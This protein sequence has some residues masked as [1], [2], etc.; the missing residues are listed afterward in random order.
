MNE[1][2]TYVYDKNDKLV[3]KINYEEDCGRT[4]CGCDQGCPLALAYPDSKNEFCGLDESEA[5]LDTGEQFWT[6]DCHSPAWCSKNRIISCEVIKL[7]YDE[8]MKFNLAEI[9]EGICKH[10]CVLDKNPEN[11]NPREMC[12]YGSCIISELMKMKKREDN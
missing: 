3:L 10:Y 8:K 11:C 4:V 12:K 5:Y 7:P 2:V 9:K 6:Y 1:K